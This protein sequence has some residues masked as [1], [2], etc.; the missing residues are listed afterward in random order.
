MLEKGSYKLKKKKIQDKADFN[1][2]YLSLF[3]DPLDLMP[4]MKDLKVH[5]LLASE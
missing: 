2:S 5:K 1:V 4:N 3:K